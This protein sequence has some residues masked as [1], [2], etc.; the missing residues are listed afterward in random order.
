LPKSQLAIFPGGHGEF[1]GELT[2]TFD[3]AV[4]A[5]TVAMVEKFLKEVEEK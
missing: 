3:S 4:V 1:L 5:A 2:M